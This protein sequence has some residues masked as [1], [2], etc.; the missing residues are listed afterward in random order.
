VSGQRFVAACITVSLLVIVAQVLLCVLGDA[1][2][3][4]AWAAGFAVVA[5]ASGLMYLRSRRGG[6]R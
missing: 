6:R 3:A 4:R 2:P 5:V 1:R